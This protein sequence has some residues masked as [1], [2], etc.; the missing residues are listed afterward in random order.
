MKKNHLVLLAIA[1]VFLFASCEKV[2]E[3]PTPTI[4]IEENSLFYYKY[5][6]VF[7]S[8]GKSLWMTYHYEKEGVIECNNNPYKAEFIE[9]LDESSL[10]ITLN[11]DDACSV[12]RY[13]VANK[14][15]IKYNEYGEFS[16]TPD[17]KHAYNGLYYFAELGSVCGDFLLGL[18]SEDNSAVIYFFFSK[19]TIRRTYETTTD[20]NGELALALGEFEFSGG[21]LKFTVRNDLIVTDHG[22]HD[23]Y[24]LDM[25][26]SSGNIF[27]WFG[28]LEV[29][30]N[31]K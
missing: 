21:P 28:S 4:K 1:T 20:S 12:N 6:D 9:I 31:K 16:L 22:Q 8:G 3:S 26:D 19:K 25:E 11:D 15:P 13:L 2:I 10:E 14:L 29:V 7:E 27:S 30:D 17:K 5:T 24:S 18:N 23:V